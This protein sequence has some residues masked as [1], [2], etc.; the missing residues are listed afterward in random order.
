MLS[1]TE[2]GCTSDIPSCMVRI[3]TSRLSVLLIQFYHRSGPI[4]N[5][6]VTC[7]TQELSYL[8][9]AGTHTSTL[10]IWPYYRHFIP[11]VSHCAAEL[12]YNVAP[13]S[14]QTCLT[15]YREILYLPCNGNS[16]PR[17]YPVLSMG[18]GFSWRRAFWNVAHCNLTNGGTCCLSLQA[19]GDLIS[20][21]TSRRVCG[22]FNKNPSLSVEH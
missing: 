21:S 22:T 19:R 11:S 6:R 7:A 5:V 18:S 3:F 17:D 1:A 4:E 8:D 2:T 14:Y 13:E 10:I 20:W 12:L 15:G 9:V 16:P